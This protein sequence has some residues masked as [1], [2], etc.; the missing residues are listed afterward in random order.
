VGL[1]DRNGRG[2]LLNVLAVI[3]ILVE[4]A[5]AVAWVNPGAIPKVDIKLDL[6]SGL[7]APASTLRPRV[8]PTIFAMET[9]TPAPTM[10]PKPSNTPP[11]CSYADL[12]TKHQGL[13]DWASTLLDTAY[14]IPASYVPPDLVPVSQAD[15]GGSA[16]V[17]SFVIN[18][19]R[20]LGNAAHDVGLNV[21]VAS[22]YRSYADQSSLFD[23]T[24]A[25]IGVDAAQAAAARPG[26]SEHQLGTA[27][28]F[29]GGE[30]W[31]EAAAWKYGFI[32]SYPGVGSPDLTCYQPEPWHYR[33]FG[34]TIAAA[35]HASGLTAREWLWAYAQ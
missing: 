32:E 26:H 28:D 6:G 2:E 35:I 1:F 19:L 21:I 27:I 9:D 11:P 13:N 25:S 4:A 16:L 18:D 30:A 15:V 24:V 23:A 7:L 5:V 20:D 14:G 33:Y 22:A 3:G 10:V 31:L 34:R 29:S 8:T 12:T 17:R